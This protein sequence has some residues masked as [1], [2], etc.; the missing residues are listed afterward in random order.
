MS[1]RE[2]LSSLMVKI[3]VRYRDRIVEM[4][5]TVSDPSDNNTDDVKR[6]RKISNVVTTVTNHSR[7][8]FFFSRE[9]AHHPSFVSIE[10]MDGKVLL[11]V[12][13]RLFLERA[14]A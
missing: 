5:D 10:Y 12:A 2:T 11:D 8:V 6:P 13:L 4:G 7:C 9:I 14:K 1:F 3:S